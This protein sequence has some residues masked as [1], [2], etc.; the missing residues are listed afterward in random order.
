M[1]LFPL[2]TGSTRQIREWYNYAYQMVQDMPRN[3]RCCASTRTSG[4]GRPPTAACNSAT[5]SGR[6]GGPA[7]IRRRMATDGD[8]IRIRLGELREDAA[9]RVQQ[10]RLSRSRRSGVNWFHQ[11]ASPFN[12]VALDANNRRIVLPGMPQ[13]FPTANPLSCCRQASFAGGTTGT[14]G[15]S[16]MSNGSGSTATTRC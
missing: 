1:N 7:W 4:R 12:Q 8:Q 15:R 16:A 5:R 11:Y 10:R 6:G 3:D 14:P 2:P 9:A 13:F